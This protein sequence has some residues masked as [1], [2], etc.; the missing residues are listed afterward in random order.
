LINANEVVIL[1]YKFTIEE[2]DKHIEQVNNYRILLSEMGYQNI[3]TYLF[4]AV[5]GKLKLV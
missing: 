4:Y 1:D 2:S 5:K 3:K